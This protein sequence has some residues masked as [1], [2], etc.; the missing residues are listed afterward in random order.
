MLKAIARFFGRMMRGKSGDFFRRVDDLNSGVHGGEP[1]IRYGEIGELPLPSGT[2]VL[3]DP[4][5]G[6]PDV[7]IENIRS[8]RVTLS[9][10]IWEYPDGGVLNR[11]LDFEFEPGRDPN[12]RRTV[13]TIG[14]D[15]AA[16]VVGDRHE[17]QAHWL[18]VGP[19]RI[20]VVSTAR[21]HRVANLLKKR[22]RLKLRQVAAY[23][24]EIV[25]PVSEELEAEITAYLETFPE[26]ADNSFVYF[27]V[28]TID[29][30][31]R[32]QRAAHPGGFIPIGSQPEP[33]MLVCQTGRGD[34]QYEVICEYDGD[35]PCRASITF[36]ED[37][38]G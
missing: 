38:D 8:R 31:Q 13:G 30:C 33:R 9:V 16:I 14:V 35:I 6:P 11:R 28:D 12:V 22:F 26:Y 4:M 17:L 19:E 24:A 1:T 34:G 15:S 5:F 37:E 27:R 3:G 2:L 21:N 20:G 32:A 29:T 23:K 25:G 36:I 18:E 10:E 7:Q